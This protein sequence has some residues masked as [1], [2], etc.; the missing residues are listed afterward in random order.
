MAEVINGYAI[1]KELNKGAFCDAYQARKGGKDFF[2]KL[3]K[4]PT[5]MSS[6]YE[7]FKKNQR[8]MIPLLKALGDLTETIVE[9]FEYGGRYYQVKELI[10]SE[11]NLRQWLETSDS[12]E[13]R[14]DVAIQFCKILMA[15]HG[16][17]IIH[18]DLKPEQVMVVNDPS[19]KSKI[20]I[21]L[22][23]FD[24]SVP[25]GNVVRYVGTPGYANI[26]GTKLSTKSDIFTFGIILCELLTGCNPYVI[27]EKE[28]DR[29]YEP[30][31]WVEWVKKKDYMKP[32]KIND[33]LP[34]VIN[35]IIEKCLDPEQ[36][37]R[38][39]LDMILAAL[40]GKPVEGLEPVVRKKIKL[41]SATGDMMIM[42][43]GMGYGRKHFKE[44]FQRTTD[45]DGNEIYKYLDK[46]YAILS[47]SQTGDT[48][49]ICCPANG[50]AKN[51]I[52]L[53]GADMPNK[54]T[55]V[56]NGDKISLYSTGQARE[57]ASFTVEII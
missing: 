6:D 49:C 2:M 29:L 24:W 18:Q 5:E 25:N 55:P 15:V 34:A 14:L 47:L 43:P 28:E 56:K 10:P 31:K 22:T 57:V 4:D 19:M 12:Y 42:V 11:T 38:P 30:T 17:N 21:V 33:E 8:K 41:R 36:K 54:P 3:Y 1:V 48:L 53:N 40:Q 32:N 51:I 26:D 50:F 39:S 52:K 37:N 35:D 45:T 7:D 27:S 16:K 9:D 46:T 20:R 44:L 23:D 13:D